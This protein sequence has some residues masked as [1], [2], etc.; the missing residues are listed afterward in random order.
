MTQTAQRPRGL[1]DIRPISWVLIG[2]SILFTG[3]S[4][5][6]SW[7][8]VA[9]TL[10]G[11]AP[12]VFGAAVMWA[13]P[14]N[15]RFYYG[16]WA[17]IAATVLRLLTVYL[18]GRLAADVPL[19][20]DLPRWLTEAAWVLEFIGLVVLGLALGGLRSRAGW[21]LFWIGVLVG[22]MAVA[23]VT[24]HPALEADP[25]GALLTAAAQA[26]PVAWGYLAAAGLDARRRGFAVG[27]SLMLAY[28][29][30]TFMLLWFPLGPDINPDLVTFGLGVLRF[31]AWV[32]LI[33]GAIGLARVH[34]QGAH[35][36]GR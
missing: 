31:V 25:I 29:G 27:G 28:L 5:E 3:L 36:G 15:R 34:S 23:W 12:L 20:A 35:S 32:A 4:A 14:Q 13:A 1:R 10:A 2:L 22:L 30:L 7:S 17:L 24:T 16:T 6:N 26:V 8:S 33:L 11:A 18:A 21:T 19:L 9:P